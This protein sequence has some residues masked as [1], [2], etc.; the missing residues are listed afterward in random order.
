[1]VLSKDWSS[2]AALGAAAITLGAGIVLSPALALFGLGAI[3]I[4]I[5]GTVFPGSLTRAF[6]W[7]LILLLLGYAFFD[8]AFA[9]IAVGPIYVGEVVLVAGLLS[10]VT[11]KRRFL[12]FRSPV[13]WLLVMLMLWGA[14]RTVPYIPIY[15][16][17][18]IRDGATW[19]YAIF[20]LLLAPLLIGSERL[21]GVAI[22]KWAR[23]VPYLLVWAPLAWLC[24]WR[25]ASSFTRCLAI[26]STPRTLQPAAKSQRPNTSKNGPN[27]GAG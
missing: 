22:E 8:R 14:I 12:V 19:G 11:D 21:A 7:L 15:G 6:Q 20:A 2:A 4:V 13:A 26:P 1:M 24:S 23:W 17:D 25:L 16:R 18:A 3:G 10:A 27:A 5:A 9:H